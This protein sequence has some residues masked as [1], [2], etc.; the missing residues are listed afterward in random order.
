MYTFT[1]L[2]KR[3]A[4]FFTYVQALLFWTL[5]RYLYCVQFWKCLEN[6]SLCRTKALS[7]IF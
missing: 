7:I 2:R 3:E 6:Y 4:I 5:P 1:I